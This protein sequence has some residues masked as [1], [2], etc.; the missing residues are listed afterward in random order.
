VAICVAAL[1]YAN[2]VF[3]RLARRLVLIP[4]DA[5]AEDRQNAEPD[6]CGGR[7]CWAANRCGGLRSAALSVDERADSA[8]AARGG[9]IGGERRGAR[10]LLV[11]PT[12]SR[13]KRQ[14]A[15]VAG[16][17]LSCLARQ[18]VSGRRRWLIDLETGDQC[19]TGSSLLRMPRV[20][21]SY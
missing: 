3:R 15:S 8:K 21:L 14:N 19:L 7:S 20:T 2:L 17:A 12:L 10:V 13:S 18:S 1:N 6:P 11:V 9:L 5:S 4:W 16:G